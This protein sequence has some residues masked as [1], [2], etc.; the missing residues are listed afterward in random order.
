MWYG[1]ML[2]WNP[3]LF[4]KKKKGVYV[5]ICMYIYVSTARILVQ[6]LQAPDL[7]PLLACYPQA[8]ERPRIRLL[9][10]T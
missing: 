5:L 2:R 9:Q 10:A 4:P 7:S 3:P 6:S 1:H 8:S